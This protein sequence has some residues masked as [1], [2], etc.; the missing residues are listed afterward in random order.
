MACCN[1]EGRAGSMNP[2][3]LFRGTVAALRQ[4]P[5]LLQ[6]WCSDEAEQTRRRGTTQSWPARSAFILSIS[7]N[8]STKP[9]C[10]GRGSWTLIH[11]DQLISA[12]LKRKFTVTTYADKGM[13]HSNT[14]KYYGVFKNKNAVNTFMKKGKCRCRNNGKK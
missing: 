5:R 11:S 12:V 4:A 3:R 14:K 7:Q 13:P 10:G 2:T 1:L 9:G 8:Y 6:E